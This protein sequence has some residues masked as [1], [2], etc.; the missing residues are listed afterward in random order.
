MPVIAI[1]NSK[2]GS[3]KTT[4]ATNLAAA[5]RRRGEDVLLVDSDPQGSARDWHA[6]SGD[7]PV[8]LAVLDRP[9]ALK[10][11][12]R[13]A[14]G[15]GFTIVD[16]AARLEDILAIAI[17]VA[18]A[19]LIPLQPS[20]YDLWATS[21][22]IDVIKARQQATGG[23]LRAAF[24][25]TRAVPGTLLGTGIRTALA[26]MKMDVLAAQVGQRQVYPQ[27]TAAG[28]TVFD[29]QNAAAR[30]EISNLAAEIIEFIK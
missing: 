7:N 23:K 14:T 22:L 27:A 5:L 12:G 16:G 26:E 4:I 9:G 1:L 17:Q 3:G 30:A 18:D 2:G 28:Q 10:T 13:L 20:P 15:Y 11:L 24:V 29:R 25:I 19:A 6:A 8:P 21:D